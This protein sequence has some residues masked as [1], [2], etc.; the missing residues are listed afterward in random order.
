MLKIGQDVEDQEE[1]LPVVPSI[2][3]KRSLGKAAW[4]NLRTMRK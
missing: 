4:V 1:A 2:E 3:N